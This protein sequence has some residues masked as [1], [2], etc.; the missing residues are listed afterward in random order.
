MGQ[1]GRFMEICLDK[2]QLSCRFASTFLT[3]AKL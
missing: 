3:H 2:W 1:P